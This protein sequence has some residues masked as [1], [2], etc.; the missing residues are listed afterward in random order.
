MK[1]AKHAFKKQ[2]IRRLGFFCFTLFLVLIL[3][4]S[5]AF[6]HDKANSD[7]ASSVLPAAKGGTGQNNLANVM[8]VGSANKLATARTINETSFDG[9]QNIENMPGQFNKIPMKSA[10]NLN[11]FLYMKAITNV[12]NPDISNT[13]TMNGA[14]VDARGFTFKF[15]SGATQTPDDK[16][17]RI[18]N[19]IGTSFDTSGP[20]A[21]RVRYLIENDAA[22]NKDMVYFKLQNFSRDQRVFWWTSSNPN[23]TITQITNSAEL[24]TLSTKRF[25]LFDLAPC[26]TPSPEPT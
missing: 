16:T 5:G 11:G 22:N 21:Y 7:S 3:S 17:L 12:A 2:K 10:N 4:T 9:T 6:L 19:S 23:T 14:S 26:T 15:T 20:R 24:T 18:C 8:G 25:Y 13:I 1:K